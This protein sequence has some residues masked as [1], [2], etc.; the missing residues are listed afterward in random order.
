MASAALMMKRFTALFT[1][2]EQTTRT[3]EKVAALR[4]YFAAAPP[5][6]AAWALHFLSGRRLRRAVSTTLLRRWVSE[7][8]GYPEWLVDECFHHAGDLSETLALLLGAAVGTIA[9]LH[10]IVE[11]RLIPLQAMP[12]PAQRELV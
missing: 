10:E 4:A 12:V 9:P 7:E 8:T 11:Q 1:A 6:D 2:L 5:R 3:S